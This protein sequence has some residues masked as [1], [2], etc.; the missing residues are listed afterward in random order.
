VVT[1]KR[2]GSPAD[3]QARRRV[4]NVF[5]RQA[6]RLDAFLPDITDA[7]ASRTSNVRYGQAVAQVAAKHA[8]Y[9]HAMVEC[10]RS[11]LYAPMPAMTRT[12]LE[13]AS[14][15]SWLALPDEPA[16]Q[17]Q[18][19]RR[20]VV[21]LYRTARN[22][23]TKLQPDAEQLVNHTM[24]QAAKRPPSFEDRLRQL[25]DHE[26]SIDG[27]I[28][29]WESHLQGVELANDFV[30]ANLAGP[31]F[32]DAKTH[33]LLGF[34]ALAV[35]YQ[36]FSIG[37]IGAARLAGRDDIVEHANRLY[38]RTAATRLEQRDKLL[39]TTAQSPS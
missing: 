12:V 22:K 8:E 14:L 7:V 27:G 34:Q 33:E 17:A 10:Y 30:H 26:R 25:D 15:L 38:E 6:R 5:G 2:F 23:G 3:I 29:F 39:A 18:R 19:L 21:H 13:D 4:A 35:G 9:A 32:T 37:L 20:V 11:V 1:I 16:D 31:L 24:G 36:Y 28:P